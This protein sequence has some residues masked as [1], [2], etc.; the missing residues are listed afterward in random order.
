[1]TTSSIIR[2]SVNADK[3]FDRELRALIGE[4]GIN[5]FFLAAARNEL[6]RIKRERAM[7]RVA[8]AGDLFPDITDSRAFVREVRS[9][10]RGRL[11]RLG[12]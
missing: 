8:E 2:Y 6:R 10:D 7:K 1:M 5:S 3:E 4:R 9:R 12:V 11:K